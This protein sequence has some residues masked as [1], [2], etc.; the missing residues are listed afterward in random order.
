MKTI[1]INELRKIEATPA[2]KTLAQRAAYGSAA[3]VNELKKL[4][5]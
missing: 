4:I 2:A 1:N 3:A 5:K